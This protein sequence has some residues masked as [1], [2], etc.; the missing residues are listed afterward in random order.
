MC[1]YRIVTWAISLLLVISIA[2]VPV[3]E[4]AAYASHSV[5]LSRPSPLAD[6]GDVLERLPRSEWRREIRSPDYRHDGDDFYFLP[7]VEPESSVVVP[8]VP[9]NGC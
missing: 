3:A 9:G 6:P 4:A 5:S 7:H 1:E 2:C 8:Q